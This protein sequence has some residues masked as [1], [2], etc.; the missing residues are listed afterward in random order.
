V[1]QLN[2]PVTSPGSLSSA[3]RPEASQQGDIFTRA[4]RLD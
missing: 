2:Q 1:S 4:R 3:L